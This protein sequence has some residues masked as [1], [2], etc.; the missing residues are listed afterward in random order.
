VSGSDDLP[1]A[2]ES[3]AFG[4]VALNDDPDLPRYTMALKEFGD[5]EGREPRYSITQLSLVPPIFQAV[6]RFDGSTYE[7]EASTKRKAKHLASKCACSGLG[8]HL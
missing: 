7:G 6:V 4:S 5:A 3:R 2:A 1:I 8:I